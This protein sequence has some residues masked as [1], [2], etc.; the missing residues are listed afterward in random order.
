[1]ILRGQVGPPI[2][3]EYEKLRS[4]GHM[5]H[6][7]EYSVSDV[8]DFLKRMGFS[9]REVRLR[10]RYRAVPLNW[11]CAAFPRLCPSFAVIAGKPA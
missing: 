8:L 5:G 10:G 7:R 2:Y 3:P 11:L 1:M 4:I 6:V 9:I